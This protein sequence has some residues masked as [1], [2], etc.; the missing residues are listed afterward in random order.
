MQ[1]GLPYTWLV[2]ARRGLSVR[3]LAGRG[4]ARLPDT[5]LGVAGHRTA[6]RVLA[7]R[8]SPIPGRAPLVEAGQDA[9]RLPYSWQGAARQGWARP[10]VAILPH[11]GHGE[12]KR[13][14]TW[15]GSAGHRVARLPYT[16]LGA[17]WQGNAGQVR[18]GQGSP[19]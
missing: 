19:T 15:Q 11:T 6:P 18:I 16:G 17:A 4:P 10:G 12:S 5:R 14:R 7:R 13:G 9:A 8:G 2:E 3:G 1:G